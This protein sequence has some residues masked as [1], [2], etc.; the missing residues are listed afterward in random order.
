M[1]DTTIDE[2][3]HFFE[4]VVCEPNSAGFLSIRCI[5]SPVEILAGTVFHV[6]VVHESGSECTARVYHG[7]TH[8]ISQRMWMQEAQALIRFSSVQ[9]PSLPR[10]LEAKFYDAEKIGIIVSESTGEPLSPDHLRLLREKP[11]VALRYFVL[12]ADALRVI[13]AHQLI[14][15]EIWQEAFEFVRMGDVPRLRLRGF[16]M[17]AFASSLA[18]PEWRTDPKDRLLLETYRQR[19]GLQ[20]RAYRAPEVRAEE[21]GSST[22]GISF[23][24]DIF[25]LGMCGVSWFVGDA[26]PDVL[27]DE[28]PTA[29]AEWAD[30]QLS[31]TTTLSADFRQLLRE[32]VRVGPAN[33]PTSSDVVNRLAV[34][35][36]EAALSGHRERPDAYVLSI[37][38]SF[39]G[40]FLQIQHWQ[41]LPAQEDRLFHYLR[42]LITRDLDDA[43][44]IHRPE[45][46]VGIV[47]GGDTQTQANCVWVLIGRSAVYFCQ[48]FIS[49]GVLAAGTRFDWVLHTNYIVDKSY[50][51][52][53]EIGDVP[54]RRRV[55][56]V[57]VVHCMNAPEV[58]PGADQRLGCP[59]WQPLLD[60]VFVASQTFPEQADIRRGHEFWLHVRRAQIENEI[61]PF[62]RVSV[63]D[64]GGTGRTYRLMSDAERDQRWIDG[65]PLR[66]LLAHLRRGRPAFHDFFGNL[67]ERKQSLEVRWIRD[68]DGRPDWGSQEG[69]GAVRSARRGEV[70]V[71]TDKALPPSIGWLRP[72]DGVAEDE[73]LRRQTIASSAFFNE[74]E[75]MEALYRPFSIAGPREAWSRAGAALEGNAREIVADMLAYFPFYAL[76][77]PPGTGKTTVVAAAV[78]A[79]LKER[80]GSRVLVSAQSHYALDELAERII[81]SAGITTNGDLIA[82]R[83]ASDYRD[84]RK[85]MQRFIDAIQATERLTEIGNRSGRLARNRTWRTR[86]GPRVLHLA[87]EWGRVA[88]NNLW[89]IQDRIRRSANVVFATTGAC[90][91]KLLGTEPFDW[92]IVEEAAKAWSTE[93][94]MPLVRGYR[95][96]LVGDHKQLPP[97]GEDTIDNIYAACQA[98]SNPLVRNLISTSPAFLSTLKVFE[99]LFTGDNQAKLGTFLNTLDMQF[100]MDDRI[101]NVVRETFYQ[102]VAR[103]R[104][105]PHLVTRRSLHGLTRPNFVTDRALVWL[106]TSEHLDCRYEKPHWSNVGEAKIVAN[107]VK[108]LQSS[109]A[110]NGPQLSIA[111]LSPYRHQNDE[112]MKLMAADL[113]QTTDS[114]QGREADIVIVSLVRTNN[115]PEDDL[116]SRIGHISVRPRAN[117][118]LSRAKK[119][120]V[121]VGD[122]I[123]FGS[124]RG[125]VWE[126]LCQHVRKYGT[127]VPLRTEAQ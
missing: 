5:G 60:E 124:T 125:S 85:E 91:E 12:A 70:T 47:T 25:S 96:T 83:V 68:S 87:G 46:A 101:F 93:L 86:Y 43:V 107:L 56:R 36:D 90:T 92:V 16:E 103:L 13:H 97:F 74:P 111:V 34:I 121:I 81:E 48:P 53:R 79:Y 33:R 44:L 99:S 38:P 37:A 69:R 114:F 113:V 49:Q 120:L 57:K 17:S 95:W 4:K 1:S 119:L 15:R 94:V 32:M 19:G 9:H 63:E 109:I 42:Q 26:P 27:S 24:S 52:V 61:Y 29:A 51:S 65:D 72:A 117:V 14:H 105:A 50:K 59:S 22:A 7:L 88:K 108:T 116:L 41:P 2:V 11:L 73:L 58:K 67:V 39:L 106:D 40:R 35:E 102:E 66:D 123:H 100:R 82:V 76:Q 10:I 89:E 112:L 23:R 75:L 77:G 55:P 20:R 110:R 71:E 45:G 64:G 122:F 18:D 118:L 54:L 6:P 31:R 80:P 3:G 62:R 30:A 78:A 8:R 127:V 84:P 21:T 28:S 104:S 126:D 115:V 98:S